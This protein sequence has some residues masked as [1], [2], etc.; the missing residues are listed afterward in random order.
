MKA[1]HA[2]RNRAG[3]ARNKTAGRS[4]SAMLSFLLGLGAGNVHATPL[5]ISDIPLDVLAGV[6]ANIILTMDDSGS[7]AW[8]FLP[9][10]INNRAY[11]QRAKSSVFN[12]IYYDPNVTYVPA[13]DKNGNSLGDSDFYAAWDNGFK[14]G[15]SKTNLAG[16]FDVIWG[17]GV[18][19]TP[20]V[21]DWNTD[22]YY[23]IFDGSKTA[24]DGN[25]CDITN[26][27][28]VNDADDCYTK[29]TVGP[30][31]GPGGTDE[32][33]NFAN[34]YSYYRLRH[35][36]AKTAATRAF[37]QLSTSIRVAWQALN[38]STTPGNTLPL[39]G[40]HRANFFNW[41]YD[42]PT[43]GGTPLRRAFGKS[44]AKYSQTG[45]NS[46]YREVPGDSSSPEFSC[47]QNFHF[48][49]TD[50]YWNSS[51]SSPRAYNYDNT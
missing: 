32:R 30:N 39:D 34:W 10:S 20:N 5:N 7:M 42:V 38:T 12:K 24:A 1:M 4:L 27:A 22:A 16:G 43:S 45:A 2:Q 11:T 14:Q 44:A 48:A 31:S 47:R 21:A 13:V 33:T 40:S 36:L 9:D 23:Y 51:N 28:H 49:F 25:P 50:G 8:G 19:Y 46:A 41:L 3:R 37:S 6:P 26:P 35:L 29:V 17:N 18:V 15:G